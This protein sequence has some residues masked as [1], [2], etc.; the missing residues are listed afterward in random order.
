MTRSVSRF[1]QS[2][3]LL[4]TLLGFYSRI[5]RSDILQNETN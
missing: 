5:A 3:E 1:A 4:T 2:R